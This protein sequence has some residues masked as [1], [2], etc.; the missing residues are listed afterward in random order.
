MIKK[1]VLSAALAAI[2]LSSMA[3]EPTINLGPID[4]DK[5]ESDGIYLL[6]DVFAI[7]VAF[8]LGGYDKYPDAIAGLVNREQLGLY[9]NPAGVYRSKPKNAILQAKEKC[10]Q[11]METFARKDCS[12]QLAKQVVEYGNTAAAKAKFLRVHLDDFTEWD[13]NINKISVANVHYRTYNRDPN[14]LPQALCVAVAE[15]NAMI[16]HNYM[17]CYKMQTGYQNNL[18]VNASEAEARALS[19]AAGT[20]GMVKKSMVF[21]VVSPLKILPTPQA[22]DQKESRNNKLV[23]IGIIEPRAII[24]GG[25]KN[26]NLVSKQLEWKT[27]RK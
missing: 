23:G 14:C 13:A 12:T 16:D 26:A 11:V 10:N 1:R 18:F 22:C 20:I 5:L 17:V 25:F 21:E 7:S 19:Q 27:S 6:D 15:Y 2:A 4:N 8:A 24:M 9:S 3:A